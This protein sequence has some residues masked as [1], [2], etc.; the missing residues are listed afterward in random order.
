MNSNGRGGDYGDQAR[1]T[2]AVII[3]N[4]RQGSVEIYTIAF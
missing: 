3:K 1:F 2:F 4:V